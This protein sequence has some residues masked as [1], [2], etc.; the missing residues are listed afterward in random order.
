MEGNT[1]APVSANNVAPE[2]QNVDG[3]SNAPVVGKAPA[4]AAKPAQTITNQKRDLTNGP[5]EKAEGDAEAKAEAK[6]EAAR[7]KYRLK[8]DG[9]EQELE[10]DDT[11]VTTRLQKAHAA[12][13]RMSEAAEIRKAFQ[14][15]MGRLK[16][17]PFSVLQDPAF[18][19]DLDALAEQRLAEK[20]QRA[21]D[22]QN[23]TEEQRALRD[24]QAQADEYRKKVE[25]F[26]SEQKA[27]A[28]QEFEAKVQA[29]IHSRIESALKSEGMEPSY[30]TLYEIAEVG[31]LSLQH[32][33]DLTPEQ[34]AAEVKARRAEREGKFK[35]QLLS[36]AKGEQLIQLLGPDVVKEVI[37]AQLATMKAPQSFAKPAPRPV[38]PPPAE[39]KRSMSPSEFRRKHL[40]GL[41]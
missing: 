19:I 1:P 35:K 10:L 30:E 28:Q 7:R 17:D 38:A 32:G 4:P 3:Q 36:G 25:K 21:L 34:L 41:E 33:I 29:D 37:R 23:M 12:E 6:A 15:V 14:E 26:E 20:Y 24:A 16:E 9:E 5:G 40:F 27:K 22:E 11:E 13:K 8:V 2:G 39:P 18:G 31:K